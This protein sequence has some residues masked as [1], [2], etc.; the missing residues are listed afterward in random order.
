MFLHFFLW[1]RVLIS[2]GC[3]QKTSQSNEP[4]RQKQ[5]SL[6]TVKQASKA[7]GAY[8]P[9]RAELED[10]PD[11]GLCVGAFRQIQANH[12][13]IVTGFIIKSHFKMPISVVNFFIPT[14]IKRV[15]GGIPFGA[16]LEDHPDV[17]LCVRSCGEVRRRPPER[18]NVRVP[19]PH[20]NLPENYYTLMNT[21]LRKLLHTRI[22]LLRTPVVVT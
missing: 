4:V 19:N 2:T 1:I 17:V 12:A 5:A 20:Q 9:F 18:H 15:L 6:R 22:I 13:Q 10:H 8:L 3:I 14:S 16:E 11:V 7:R 21:M